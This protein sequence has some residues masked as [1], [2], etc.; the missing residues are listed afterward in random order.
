MNGGGGWPRRAAGR[1]REA[2]WPA[3]QAALTAGAAWWV[4]VRLLDHP[5]PFFAPIAAIVCLAAARGTRG[6]QALDML[7]GVLVGVVVGE[8]ALRWVGQGVGAITLVTLVAMV[9]ASALIPRPL[10]LIQA[11]ASAVLVVATHRWQS[12]TGRLGDALVGGLLA[13]LV[14][15]V[16]LT[17]DPRSLLLEPARAALNTLA[18]ALELAAAAVAEGDEHAMRRAVERAR[19]A[20]TEVGRLGAARA[21]TRVVVSSTLRGRARARQLREA[22]ARLAELDLLHGGVLQ[23]TRLLAGQPAGGA[24]D[25]ARRWVLPAVTDLAGGLRS[26][27]AGELLADQLTAARRAARAALSRAAAAPPGAEPLAGAVRV[28][29][30]DLARFSAPPHRG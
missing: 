29:A 30:E 28:A 22:D 10:P 13:L 21:T 23:L 27:A 4:A 11:G 17:V 15:Q 6:R 12:G 26:A 7:A 25:G 18:D 3:A 16:L 20:H 5:S 9:L 8:V 2:A 1:V 14:S 24:D 19:D